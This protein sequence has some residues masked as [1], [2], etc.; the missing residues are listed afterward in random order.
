M[1][2]KEEISKE[3]LRTNYWW[4]TGA[5]DP[6]DRQEFRRSIFPELAS[7]LSE[8]E[9]LGIIG[10]RRTGKTTLMY[11]LI[12]HLLGKVSD[13][14]S[15][16][17]FTFDNPL[18]TEDPEILPK[19]I[20]TYRE[21]AQVKGTRFI[22]FDEIQYVPDWSRWLK[23]HH[24]RKE[25]MKFI[26]SGSS[27]RLIY[28]NTTE[29]LTGR[30][31]F[32]ASNPF[33]FAEYCRFNDGRLKDFLEVLGKAGPKEVF[34]PEVRAGI[35]RYGTDIL[36]LFHQYMLKGGI[37]QAFERDL[38][39]AH[40]WLKRDY[41]DMIFFR[42]LVRLFEVRDVRLLEEVFYFAAGAHGQRI[43]YSNIAN[44]LGARVETV[45][46]YLGYLE[47]VDVLRILEQYSGSLKK[48]LRAEKKVYVTDSGIL[49]AVQ[50]NG[51]EVL[52]NPER[53]GTIVEGIVAM[54]LLNWTDGFFPRTLFYWRHVHELDFV[55]KRGR[56]LLPIEVKYG[57]KVQPRDLAGLFQFMD[58]YGVST[59]M[60]VN[61]DILRKDSVDGKEL[62]YIPAWLHLLLG[63]S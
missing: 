4:S 31:T 34:R 61:R 57:T 53:L 42:D 10:A 11:Q 36:G 16:M 22:F 63:K 54:H 37:P 48:S 27:G 8:K 19:I 29:S 62:L 35:E 55:W 1:A 23:V 51:E 40:A 38:R 26:V 3:I 44:T 24:D 13:P 49:N 45:K 12:E 33:T 14:K 58:R 25:L 7:H 15:V 17:L 18:L 50:G 41:L 2:T 30:I 59:G 28:H 52:G 20:E 46:Q 56:S 60:V 39:A 5:L 6:K 43:S 47:S 21:L 9:I 32:K